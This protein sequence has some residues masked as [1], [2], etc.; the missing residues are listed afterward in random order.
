MERI[1]LECCERIPEMNDYQNI[2]NNLKSRREMPRG[3]HWSKPEKNYWPE[4]IL[5]IMAFS[6]IIAWLFAGSLR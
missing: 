1:C 2:F 5:W 6:F 3:T 4:V